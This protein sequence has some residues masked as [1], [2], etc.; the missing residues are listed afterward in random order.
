[1]ATS[2]Q[3]SGATATLPRCSVT[4]WAILRSRPASCARPSSF[5]PDNDDL[6]AELAACLTASGDIAGATAAIGEALDC[7]ISLEGGASQPAI[8]GAA[9]VALLLLRSDLGL[10]L[11]K[12]EPAMRDLEEAYEIDPDR[13]RP[14]LIEALDRQRGLAAQSGDF[15]TEREV[16]MRLSKLLTAAGDGERT[17]AL[18]MGWVER[19]PQDRDPLYSLLEMDKAA[20]NWSGVLD[21]CAR[22][23]T[24]ETGEAQVRAALDLADAAEKAERPGEALQ[25]LEI[26]HQAQPDS[27]E[28]R[29][30][31]RRIYEL[32]GAFEK[33]ATVLLADGDH[34]S[35]PELRYAAY[36]RA[37]EVLLV[38]LGS[39]DAALEPARKARELKPQEHD[40]TVLHVN[41]LTI[42]G[43]TDG[44][45]AILEE[46]IGQHKRRSPQLAALKQRMARIAAVLGDRD[47]QLSWLKEAFD[48]DR[49][50]PEIAA[51]LAQL[52]TEVGDYDLAVKPLRAITL[53]D[54]PQPITRVMA[55]LWE[56]K[57]EHA[58]G[59]TAKAELWA[60]KALRED[61]NY[62]DAQTFLDQITQ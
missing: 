35:D 38:S 51:E 24:L 33:L 46:A 28:I 31:L 18:L 5:A 29:D 36:R 12:E 32:S 1:M 21:V 9:R 45:I 49:K 58:R 52:A 19:Q 56:A 41:I 50:N 59:N 23:V 34:A 44:A 48:V 54:D 60:R 20:G 62:A 8:R 6:V 7:Q 3:P 42:S 39:P 61:P 4:P 47:G 17:R 11:G 40:A 15:A 43:Q 2:P 10:Q 16:V 14:Q 13:I 22:L 57:I 26:A 55:F 30:R 25:A 53:M 27:G 37:A